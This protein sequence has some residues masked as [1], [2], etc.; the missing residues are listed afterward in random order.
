[1]RID[2]DGGEIL[3]E[4]AS[5]I[6]ASGSAPD[7]QAQDGVSTSTGGGSGGGNG[8]AGGQASFQVRSTAILLKALYINFLTQVR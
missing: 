3:L 2:A 6:N 4:S 5:L 7:D 8:A 1:V